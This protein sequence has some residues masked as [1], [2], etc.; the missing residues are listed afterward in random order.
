M[1]HRRINLFTVFI[2]FLLLILGGIVH[3]T[4]SS[5]ACPDWPL[6]Y[7][8]VF[9]VMEGGVLIEHS[10]RLLASLVGFLTIILVWFSFKRRKESDTCHEIYKLSLLALLF[11]IVQGILGGITVIYKLP[12]IVSTTHLGLSM[13]FFSTLILLHHKQQERDHESYQKLEEKITENDW[14]P[15]LKNWV[16]GTGVL[17]YLQIIWGA[18]MRHS[19]SGASCGLGFNNAVKCMDLNLWKPFWWPVSAQSQVHMG[20]RA[21]AIVV[22]IFV[23]ITTVKIFK[24]FSG[25]TFSFPKRI[26]RYALLAHIMIFIQVALGIATVGL[27]M[28]VPPTTAHLAGGALCLVLFWKIYLET[29]SF[30]KL[31]FG[32]ELPSFFADVVDLTKPKLSGLVLSTA[33]VGM[34]ISPLEIPFF[35]A[36]WALLL[37]G[38]VVMGG[39]TLNCFMEKDIDG[40]MERTKDRPL[41]SGRMKPRLALVLGMSLILIAVPLL[42]FTINWITAGLGVLAA[43][44]YLF[45]YTPMKQKSELAVYV[46]AI[47]GAIPP[48]MGWTTLSGALDP[49]AG[50][51][52]LIL[53]VW[54]LPHFLAISIY[55]AEDYDAANIKVYPN[56]KGMSATRNY[57]FGFTLLLAATAIMPSIWGGASTAYRNCAIGLSLMFIIL[58]MMAFGENKE[59]KFMKSWARKYFIASIIYLPLLLGAMIFL[60]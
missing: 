45:S 5:L 50:I 53:F 6:C 17:I 20:H 3:N 23:I 8:Q 13:V 25:N 51:L 16:F 32:K 28:S 36:L 41:P 18:F 35:K 15:N 30:E 4:E 54:Q 59:I 21:F 12:T 48:V 44:L 57:I 60:R 43:V 9:P 27:H 39:T 56:L 22:T 33:L 40:L 55:H 38:M 10:H 47:P 11:V 14:N 31:H 7:G 1:W 34:M 42:A 26:K 29:V 24:Q 19:G 46:G 49:M 37:I 2:T 52:F 58:S